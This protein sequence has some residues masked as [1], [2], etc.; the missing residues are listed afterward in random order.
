MLHCFL[1]LLVTAM[2]YIEARQSYQMLTYLK[3]TVLSLQ[4]VQIQF[5]LLKTLCVVS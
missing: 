3:M 1:Y 5:E 4:F 2:L